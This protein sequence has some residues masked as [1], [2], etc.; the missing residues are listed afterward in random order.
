MI[1]SQI[2]FWGITIFSILIWWQF[3]TS[4]DGRVRVLA[5]RLFAVKAW[6][7]GLA[8]A[9]Y[10][11]WDFGYLRDMSGL[12]LRLACNIPMVV[13]MFEWYRYIK[14]KR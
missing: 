11:I 3:Y 2:L 6:V 9:Y 12:W 14:Y 7:Y 13:V 5:I 1:A 8:G 4:V 10:L